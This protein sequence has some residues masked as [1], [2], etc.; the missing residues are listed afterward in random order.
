MLDLLPSGLD[1]NDVRFYSTLVVTLGF[2]ALGWR[3]RQI[4]RAQR[5]EDR[6][7]ALAEAVN[8]TGVMGPPRPVERVRV[9]ERG[10]GGEGAC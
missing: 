7:L 3:V 9:W 8:R 4:L 1:L 5:A 2:A 10:G 6:Q